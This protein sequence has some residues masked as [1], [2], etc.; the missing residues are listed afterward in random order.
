MGKAT[1]FF[2]WNHRRNV[3]VVV[4]GFRLGDEVFGEAECLEQKSSQ[5]FE[6]R[7]FKTAWT[8]QGAVQLGAVFAQ[9]DPIVLFFFAFVVVEV[10]LAAGHRVVASRSQRLDHRDGKTLGIWRL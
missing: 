10:T 1:A 5:A 4:D 8:V 6:I 9:G 7:F 3:V 2:R